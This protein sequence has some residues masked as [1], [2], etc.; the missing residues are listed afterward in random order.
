MNILVTGADGYIGHAVHHELMN[1]RQYIRLF[2][3]DIRNAADVHRQVR[4]CDLVLHFAAKTWGRGFEGIKF[5]AAHN[6]EG[7]LNVAEACARFDVK[8]AYA[9]CRPTMGAY[10]QSMAMADYILRREFGA[11]P[12][13]MAPVYGPGQRP[14]EPWGDGPDRLIPRWVCSALTGQPIPL[15]Q[16]PDSVPNLVYIDDVAEAVADMTDSLEQHHKLPRN[17]DIAGSGENLTHIALAVVQELW[18]QCRLDVPIRL[19]DN[20]AGAG[21]TPGPAG[22]GGTPLI[23]GLRRTVSY[24]R[25]VL[26]CN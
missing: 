17:L 10:G 24:Y 6:T 13:R 15:T 12:I 23:V 19:A 14:P 21:F 3:G 5:F 16:N 2:C 26:S 8:L 18:R 20:L 4:S 11:T 9:A 22:T 7:A 1:R 25:E